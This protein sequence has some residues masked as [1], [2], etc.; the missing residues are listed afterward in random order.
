MIEIYNYF[1]RLFVNPK[2]QQLYKKIKEYTFIYIGNLIFGHRST[3]YFIYFKIIY[4]FDLFQQKVTKK[5]NCCIPIYREQLRLLN[6][7]K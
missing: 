2:R 4:I 7:T 6:T 5:I 1:L 3:R